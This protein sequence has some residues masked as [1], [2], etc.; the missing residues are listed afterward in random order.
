MDAIQFRQT[1]LKTLPI[2]TQIGQIEPS[3]PT[4]AGLLLNIGGRI[5]EIQI[6]DLGDSEDVTGGDLNNLSTGYD[7]MPWA[8]VGAGQTLDLN[9]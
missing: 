2:G 4:E 9:F 1:M 5:I 8:L 7:E 3:T 6:Y